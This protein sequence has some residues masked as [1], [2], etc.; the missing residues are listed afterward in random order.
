VLTQVSVKNFKRLKRLKTTL[1]RVTTL[2]G[3]NGAGKS[4]FVQSLVWLLTDKPRGSDF[5]RGES[6]SVTIKIDSN[7]VTRTK[8]SGRN[9]YR[10]PGKAPYKDLRR[11]VPDKLSKLFNVCDESFQGQFEGPFWLFDSPGQISRHLNSVVDLEV[12]DNVMSSIGKEVRSSVN[13]VDE[14]KSRLK[15]AKD[16]LDSL[17]WVPDLVKQLA[18]LKAKKRKARLTALAA[19]RL[20]YLIGRWD[21]LTRRRIIDSRAILCGKKAVRSGNRLAELRNRAEL[22]ES[23]VNEWNRLDRLSRQR[24]PDIGPLLS[25]R[26]KADN[27]AQ[28]CG[29]LEELVKTHDNLEREERQCDVDIRSLE[30]EL[31]KRLKGRCPMCGRGPIKSR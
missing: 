21:S 2:V 24:V 25:S 18:T 6:C 22:L 31:R 3:P 10:L 28:A 27:I 26:T 13:S 12:I 15:A 23:L 20:G 19:R 8:A 29:D 11:G 1:G 7:R 4:S 30:T 17:S 5:V 14:S 9:E 16:K